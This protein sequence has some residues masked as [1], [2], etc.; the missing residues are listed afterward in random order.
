VVEVA[1]LRIGQAF[2]EHLRQEHQVVVVNPDDVVGPGHLHHG[3]AEPLVHPLIDLP[4]L[5][6]VVCREVEVV[7]ERPEG[8]VAEP[9]V[10]VLDIVRGEKDR[11]ALLFS[12]QIDDPVF[13]LFLLPLDVHAGPADPETLV[14]LVK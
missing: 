2:A 14:G 6:V 8:V 4:R 12:E 9:V 13:L 7:E 1:D 11:V 3:I 10:V 5:R